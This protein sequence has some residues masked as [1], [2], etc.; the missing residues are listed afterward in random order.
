M[1]SMR[2]NAF[3]PWG[4]PR[5]GPLESSVTTS[6]RLKATDGWTDRFMVPPYDSVIPN[7]LL[8]N[9]HLPGSP[10]LVMGAAFTGYD[11]MMKAYKE[12]LEHE[13]RFFVYGDAML[14]LP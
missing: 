5:F 14:V 10:V 1:G 8:T 13:Y 3:A 6:S 4:F 11:L 7:A 2:G 9:F 12:A